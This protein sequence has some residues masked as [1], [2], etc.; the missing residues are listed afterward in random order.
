MRPTG[1]LAA[2]LE[3]SP[4]ASAIFDSE[5]IAVVCSGALR[6]LLG[7][8]PQ[9]FSD[10]RP[11][12]GSDSAWR[13]VMDHLWN[14]REE[15]LVVPI[16]D[17]EG[18]P[19][20]VTWR[21]DGLEGGHVLLSAVVHTAG[22]M[23]GAPM[24]HGLTEYISDAA[25]KQREEV[26][27]FLHDNIGQDLTGLKMMASSLRKRLGG[28]EADER[29]RETAA[30]IADLAEKSL[31]QVRDLS[32]ALMVIDFREI[33]LITAMERMLS[34][35][36]TLSIPVSL[37]A[38]ALPR[39]MPPQRARAVYNIAREAVT[40]ALRH[41]GADSVEVRLRLVEGDLQMQVRDDGSGFDPGDTSLGDCYGILLMRQRALASGLEL[42]IRSE[43]G[44]GTVVSCRVP[45]VIEG[46]TGEE[47]Q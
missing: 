8:E 37:K 10:L 6:Q 19:H 3:R 14:A 12:F 20:P 33:P 26:A 39:R 43:Q 4:F 18:N 13:T 34:S 17:S 42:E 21:S 11:L 7:E 35:V 2:L 44:R 30:E 25:D 16:S 36:S 28:E 40:N 24:L 15:W 23:S 29:L 9:S 41:S 38:D 1:L 32:H 27:E 22:E 46:D 47:A 31:Q 45:E 5:G